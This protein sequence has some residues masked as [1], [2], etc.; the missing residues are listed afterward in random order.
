M[1]QNG[2]TGVLANGTISEGMCLSVKERKHLAEE[3]LKACRK[4]GLTFMVQVGGTTVTDVHDL[5]EH[6]E[7]IGADAVLCL[8]ELFFKPT[9]AEDLIH[10]LQEV[11]S[12]CPSRTLL[13]YHIPGQ[14]EVNRK[15]CRRIFDNH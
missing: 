9:S 7:K 1:K 5:A 6:A 15:Y 13:Y 4:Y 2:V 8:P 12:H 11:G 10:Y 3:W 14:T